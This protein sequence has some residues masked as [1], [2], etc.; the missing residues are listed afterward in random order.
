MKFVRII[1]LLAAACGL[2][3]AAGAMEWT[4]TNT[5]TVASNTVLATEMAVLTAQ[6]TIRGTVADDL[7]VLAGTADIEG[8]L[9]RDL[10]AAADTVRVAGRAEQHLRA[11]ARQTV[12]LQGRVALGVVAAAGSTVKVGPS[13][14]LGG[15][16]L[17]AGENV[18]VEGRIDG[19]V[20]IVA[21]HVTLSGHY[22][23]G[24][25]IIANDIVVLPG[26]EIRGDLIYTSQQELYLNEQVAL[27]GRL[28]RWTKAAQ[29][30]DLRVWFAQ[31]L[32]L[33]GIWYLAALMVGLPL[34]LF[35]PRYTLR[36]ARQIRL[37]PIRCAMTGLL[38]LTLVPMLI[39]MLL[40]SRIGAALGLILAAGYLVLM[41]L[42][43]MAAGLLLGLYLVFRRGPLTP[44]RLY[45]ALV[46]GLLA[47]YLAGTL[48]LF[49]SLIWVVVAVLGMGALAQ[50]LRE[51][52]RGAPH[53]APERNPPPLAVNK[54]G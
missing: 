22:G 49:E 48:P 12:E 39:V 43:K 40:F 47:L 28:I 27:H 3:G 46:A 52:S 44:A 17:L 8:V 7:F 33:R 11:L 18:I 19:P 25:R 9:Q 51:S 36:A 15:S 45:A 38:I 13:A 26:A 10:W 42:A 54:E 6:A 20:K 16:A 23:N 37:T 4:Q 21:Q 30:D 24:L 35:Y 14:E 31:S 5:F 32:L 29:A 2:A 50:G 41:Y 34:I 1:F 53:P